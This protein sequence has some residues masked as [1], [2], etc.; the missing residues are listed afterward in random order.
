MLNSSKAH[1]YTAD[2][3]VMA[4]AV[5]D[6]RP[7]FVEDKKIKKGVGDE[8][9]LE[10]EKTQDILRTL[11]ADRPVGQVLVGFSLET[12]NEQ[13]YALKKLREKNLDLIVMN[14]L[15]DPGAGFNYDTNK[16]TLFDRNGVA[17]DLPL[18]SKQEVA[19]DIVTAITDIL[20][21]RNV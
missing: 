6:Y 7:R 13:E 21:S 4:A 14:S 8:L 9:I 20:Q 17:K 12:N 11:G 16:V 1:F 18:K 2:V 5:A 3:V 15:N 10:L 19:K